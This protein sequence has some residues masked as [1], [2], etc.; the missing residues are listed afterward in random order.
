MP[1][2]PNEEAFQAFSGQSW[3]LA[4]LRPWV[5]FGSGPFGRPHIQDGQLSVRLWRNTECF[6]ANYIATM[7]A[8]FCIDVY[9]NPRWCLGIMLIVALAVRLW[10][11]VPTYSR[12]R[13][14]RTTAGH[15]STVSRRLVQLLAVAIGPVTAKGST[16]AE[17]VA[18]AAA[19]ALLVPAL[20]I[21]VGGLQLSLRWLAFSTLLGLG[22]A[23]VNLP[24][25]DPNDPVVLSNRT[26]A[27]KQ[28]RMTLFT[29]LWQPFAKRTL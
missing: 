5:E 3:V 13:F 20:I 15:A 9:H 16:K 10:T 21:L 7:V 6:Q 26:V 29:W 24:N 18:Y 19:V 4:S 11:A 8:G 27:S 1:S 23:F 25:L 17:P 22:H 28:E 12:P 14:L 2:R